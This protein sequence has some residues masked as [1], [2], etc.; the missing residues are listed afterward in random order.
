MSF[1]YGRKF[2]PE[3]TAFSESGTEAD[4]SAHAL[5]CFTDNRET[6]PRSGVTITVMHLDEHIKDASVIP[7]ARMPMPLSS[8]HSRRFAFVEI[9]GA[10]NVTP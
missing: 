4:V 10:V 2:D 5:D 7:R 6:N 9:L 3:A 1:W 8:I